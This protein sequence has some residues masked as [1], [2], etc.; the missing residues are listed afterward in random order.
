MTRPVLHR[1]KCVVR[2]IVLAL[3]GAVCL[4][5]AA[6]EARQ[7]IAEPGYRPASDYAPGFVE[8]VG[9]TTIDVLPT[10]IRR[11]DR[12]AHSFASQRQ[13][14]DFLNENS[15][16]VA[17]S[18]SRRIDP[19]ALPRGSQWEIFE[20]GISAVAATVENRAD[21]APYT[22]VMEI[23]VPRDKEVFGIELYL[24]DERGRS[25]FSFLLNAHHQLFAEAGLK[26]KGSSLEDREAMIA[27]A[28]HTGL[29]ALEAQ[30]GQAIEC[31]QRPQ[32]PA[33]TAGA[34]VLHDFDGALLAGMDEW[35]TPIGY[36]TF[37]GPDSTVS[38]TAAEDYPSR[39]DTGD[40][41]RVLQ[42]DLNVTSWGGVINRFADETVTRWLPQDWRSLDGFSFWLFGANSGTEMF[43][44]VFDNRHLCSKT[45]DAERFRYRFWDDV[46]GWRLIKVR[47]EDLARWDVGNNPPD[48]GL[49]LGEVHGWGLGTMDTGGPMKLYVDDFR[50][51]DDA[52]VTVPPTA[53]RIEHRLFAETRLGEGVSRIETSTRDDGRLAVEQVLDLSCECAR[54][55]LDREFAYF[56]MDER[57]LL[58][59]ERARF[60]L[61]FYRSRPTD[62]P[63]QEIPVPQDEGELPVN[64]SAAMPAEPLSRICPP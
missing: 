26:A 43:F 56:R 22:L 51:L 59:N 27:K 31:A 29:L 55:A 17:N 64:V 20:Q 28:T 4:S 24:L 47:F 33:A 18:H 49:G 21:A 38:I 7:T 46:A 1:P 61:T 19:G 45:D 25:A 53:T 34:G 32:V 3:L 42:L 2:A 12:T 48:D 62:V 37:N 8:A 41:N 60:R 52:S 58:S 10:M 35:G 9:T 5:S 40:G 36:S 13:I 44:D 6:H 15:I 39:P 23:L 54:L 11:T 30:L 16:A 50:L 14:V 63:V 57:E